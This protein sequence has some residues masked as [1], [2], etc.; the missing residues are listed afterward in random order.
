VQ[1]AAVVMQ[2]PWHS[3]NPIGRTGTGSPSTSSSSGIPPSRSS[4]SSDT[5]LPHGWNVGLHWMP[6]VVPS[7]VACP[8]GGTLQGEQDVPHEFTLVSE[9]HAPPQSCVIAGHWSTQVSCM[10]MH[11][12]A[13]GF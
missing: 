9:A 11:V 2:A 12:P 8:L 4:G 1:Q 7:H 13:H 3:L 6:Q 5:R 10:G